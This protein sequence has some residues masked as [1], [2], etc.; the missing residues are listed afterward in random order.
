MT[1]SWTNDGELFQLC[2]EELFTAVVGDV[3]DQ[4]GYLQQ[5]LPPEIQPLREDM[6]IVGR[7][8][9][10]LEADDLGGEGPGRCNETLNQPFG[11]MLRALD[12]LNSG[13]VYICSGASPTYALWGE[14]MSTAAMNRGAVGAIVNGYSRDTRG[15]LQLN[16][17]TFSMGRY[18]QDQRPRGKIVDLRCTL[19]FGDVVVKPG[20]LIFGDVDGVCVVPHSIEDEVIRL[21]LE[22]ASGER[23]VFNAIKGGMGAQEAWDRYGIM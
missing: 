14:L 1:K 13:D 12:E 19:K 2:R 8:M 3:M 6:L 9:T 21:A 18:A 7:A 11:L 10:V 23:Q 20:D 16:F 5:F 4:L 22:K 15:I 17:P